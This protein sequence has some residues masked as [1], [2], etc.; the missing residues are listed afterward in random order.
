MRDRELAIWTDT[1]KTKDLIWEAYSGYVEAYNKYVMYQRL[2]TLNPMI[3]ASLDRYA[4]YF[5]E[6]VRYFLEQF[7]DKFTTKELEQMKNLF[8]IKSEGFEY[9]DY[10]FIRRMFSKFMHVTGIKD[11]VSIKDNRSNL[12]RLSDKLGLDRGVEDEEED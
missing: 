11:V 2:G 9:R 10:V 1:F 4:F 8:D 3:I 12:K 6:E 5:Y 7:K